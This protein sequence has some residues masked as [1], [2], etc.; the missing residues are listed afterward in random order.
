MGAV[1]RRHVLYVGGFDPRSP[2]LTHRRYAEEGAKQAATAG[3]TLQVGPRQ[4]LSAHL[5]AWSVRAEMAGTRCETQFACLCWDDIV[6]AHWP[7][8][9]L[10]AA[11][12]AAQASW[13]LWRSG[14]AWRTLKTSW[15]AF[16]ALTLPTWIATAALAAAAVLTA[17]A[18]VQ[19]WL[20][21]ALLP[22]AAGWLWR[23]TL[24][25]HLPWLM[26]S[27]ALTVK[28][29]RG[30]T[31]ELDERLALGVAHLVRLIDAADG[32]EVLLTGH[33][34][35]AVL[36][37]RIAAQALRQ[38]P[39]ARL[40]LLTLGHGTQILSQQP[41]A[42]WFCRELAALANAPGLSWVDVT[43]PPDA[44]CMALVS[45][46]W[47]AAPDLTQAR[48]PTLVNARFAQLI[49]P[50]RYAALKRDKYRCHFQYLMA[51][52]RPGAWDFFA[53]TAGPL[54][55]AARFPASASVLGFTRLQTLGG[56][57]AK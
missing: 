17:L 27:V 6:R 51:G 38:R 20:A 50:A 1:R 3:Y 45:P 49:D 55:L 53:V 7:R 43:A 9:A 19:P 33:S 56:P 52:D 28:Q 16:V 25:A 13:R 31:P 29:A 15:P 2:A 21:L 48:A 37:M 34:A 18:R 14:V 30:Q 36:A 11:R 26:R 41:E 12:A 32:D 5:H 8:G 46:T 47:Y 35:G 24:R 39:G 4:R 57:G 23:L 10:G 54:P 44:C 22:L 42:D 40:A